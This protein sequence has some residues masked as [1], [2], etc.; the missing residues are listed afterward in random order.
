MTMSDHEIDTSILIGSLRTEY[1]T[2]EAMVKIYCKDHHGTRA[3]C[4]E[5]ADFLHYALIKLDR[6]PYGEEKPTCKRCPIHCYKA[7]YKERSR[8]IMRYSGPKMLLRHPILAIR[9]LVAGKK[10]VPAKPAPNASNR[11]KRKSLNR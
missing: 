10:P 1:K 7:E 4:D 9:H 2:L 8:I 6:C 3:L 11:H 5:C